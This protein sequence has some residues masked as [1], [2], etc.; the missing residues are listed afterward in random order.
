MIESV[1]NLREPNTY[2]YVLGGLKPLS[3]KYI[4]TVFEKKGFKNIEK[5]SKLVYV[6][7]IV[8]TL[9][10]GESISPDNEIEFFESINKQKKKVL[11]YFLGGVTFAEIAA[12]RFLSE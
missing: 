5:K 11:V 8:S 1:L 4:E 12:L 10:R 3:V 6:Y 7:V 2:A 9:I